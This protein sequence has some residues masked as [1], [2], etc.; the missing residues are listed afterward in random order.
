MLEGV[1]MGIFRPDH[2]PLTA[3]HDMGF[4][5]LLNL[6]RY[7]LVVRDRLLPASSIARRTRLVG[8]NRTPGAVVAKHP[9]CQEPVWETRHQW[10]NQVPKNPGHR[11]WR[12]PE[13]RKGMAAP[14]RY[15]GML[16]RG[17]KF[18]ENVCYAFALGRR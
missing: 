1:R 14:I 18:Q 13:A 8:D 6:R 10:E 9:I 7:A 3:I 17:D 5:T 15:A 12:S 16:T 4:L 2:F 11:D